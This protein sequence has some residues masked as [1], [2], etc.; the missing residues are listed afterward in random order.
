MCVNIHFPAAE[1]SLLYTSPADLFLNRGY[2]VEQA[3]HVV[4]IMIIIKIMTIIIVR[5][6]HVMSNTRKLIFI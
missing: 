5:I 6:L 1:M 3:P 4:I 2:L